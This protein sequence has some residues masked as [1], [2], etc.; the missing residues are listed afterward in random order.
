MMGR[1]ELLRASAMDEELQQGLDLILKTAS[2]AADLTR[3]LLAFS[4]KQVLQPRVI[5]LNAVVHDVERM[6]ARVIGENI[7]LQ[8]R[9]EDTLWAVKADAGQIEQVIL[10]LVVN[11][12]DAMPVGGNI[13]IE[14]S[15]VKLDKVGGRQHIGI[16]PGEYVMLAVSDTGIGMA[17]EIQAKIFEPF[18]TTKEQGKGTGLGLATVYGIVEQS[19]GHVLVDSEPHRGTTFKVYFPR[20]D[21]HVEA[22]T[23]VKAAEPNGFETIL[24][25]EDEDA[26]RDLIHEILETRGYKVLSTH[27]PDEALRVCDAYEGTIHLAITDV[28]MPG[29]NGW[30]LSEL[31]RSKRPQTKIL[32]MSG[33]TDGII[34]GD[35][36]VDVRDTFLQKP[37]TVDVLCSKVRAVL[38]DTLKPMPLSNQESV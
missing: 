30:S 4:R 7:G 15:N 1:S 16:G 28:V 3:Q 9:Q 12:R 26:V 25:A 27:G 5:S 11:S 6:L 19:G 21:G 8:V 22:V 37:V 24:L 34:I 13:T 31:I 38:D 20:F 36:A 2:R 33:Y 17:P 14:T 32:Y 10:N 23:R 35:G 18:F 29:M